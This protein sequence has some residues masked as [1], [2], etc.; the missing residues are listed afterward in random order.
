MWIGT[1]IVT[2]TEIET[3]TGIAAT[4]VR[5]TEI[6]TGIGIGI[7]IEKEKE[8]ETMVRA[9]VTTAIENGTKTFCAYCKGNQKWKYI[10]LNDLMVFLNIK[11][12]QKKSLCVGTGTPAGYSRV[13]LTLTYLH[14]PQTT[15]K[16]HT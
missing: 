16:L 15:K 5:T 2:E 14:L 9:A 6:A 4:L 12:L 7:E 8:T 3:G 10:I 1:G 11:K 13:P